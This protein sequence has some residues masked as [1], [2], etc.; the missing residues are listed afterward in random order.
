MMEKCQKHTHFQAKDPY[1]KER[2]DLQKELAKVTRG[3]DILK[4]ALASQKE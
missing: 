1:D 4:K 3:R 2:F